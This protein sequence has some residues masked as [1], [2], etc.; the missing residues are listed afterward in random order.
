MRKSQSLCDYNRVLS[1]RQPNPSQIKPIPNPIKT[2]SLSN[3]DL[4]N[5]TNEYPRNPSETRRNS[6]SNSTPYKTNSKLSEQP[7]KLLP[8]SM[9]S[10][11]PLNSSLTKKTCSFDDKSSK[12]NKSEIIVKQTNNYKSQLYSEPKGSSSKVLG[13]NYV[14]DSESI[15]KHSQTNNYKP[16]SNSE[17]NK[18]SSQFLASKNIKVEETKLQKQTYPVNNCKK[19]RICY[20]DLNEKEYYTPKCKAHIYCSSCIKGE[21]TRYKKVDCTHCENF[22]N[23]IKKVEKKGEITC[24]LCILFPQKKHFSCETH[25]YCIDCFNYL[26]TNEFNY[27]EKVNSCPVCKKSFEKLKYLQ[28]KKKTTANEINADIFTPRTL[29]SIGNTTI[30]TLIS[31]GF[32]DPKSEPDCYNPHSY[33]NHNKD[34]LK[35]V[36][37]N[38]SMQSKV[39]YPKKHPENVSIIKKPK[40]IQQSFLSSSRDLNEFISCLICGYKQNIRAFLCNHNL[41]LFCLVGNCC[42]EIFNFFLQYQINTQIA[43]KPFSY[44]CPFVECGKIIDVP[45]V[46]VLKNLA[47]FLEDRESFER[48]K[49]FEFLKDFENMKIWI[50]FFDGVPYWICFSS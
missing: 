16:Q 13:S 7:S 31:L 23:S 6:I 38:S 26:L 17:P 39:Q 15:F 32:P 22:F 40:K 41:C 11:T 50:P 33:R 9:K 2:P 25:N 47:K 19:C 42:K 28:S 24:S 43:F 20:D 27:I 10:K 37:Q 21:F 14:K 8:T 48:F 1:R 18:S 3:L 45:T 5:L 44:K 34:L 30:K 29:N 12:V 35:S 46:M 36:A 4:S 49:G